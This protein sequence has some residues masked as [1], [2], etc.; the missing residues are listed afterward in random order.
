MFNNCNSKTNGEY[1]FYMKIKDKIDI[2]FDVG[3]RSDSEYIN[4]NGIVHYFDPVNEYI[5]KLKNIPNRNKSAY[6]NNFGLG[7]DNTELY[8][9][10]RYQ[11]FY[12]RINSC[13]VS[14]E[15]NKVLLKI[16]KSQDYIIENNINK[17]DFLKIDTEGF[18]FNVIQGFEET[19]EKVNI[20]QF[21]YG[22]TYLDNNIKLINIKQYLEEKGFTKF[23]Y[24]TSYGM[25]PIIDFTDHYQ[26]CNIV[27]INKKYNIDDLIPGST[28]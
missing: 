16:R 12:N 5:E 19:I 14:D 7:T 10:P 27:C 17:I 24:L 13:N 18:E 25:E 8:Y 22:G 21:E 23:Y 6:F 3:C 9:Y 2:I 28:Y 15:S 4:F 26:Y 1:L 11:S 20:I